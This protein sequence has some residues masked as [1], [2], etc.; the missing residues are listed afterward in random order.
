MALVP[1]SVLALLLVTSIG[2][3]Q[4]GGL[5]AEVIEWLNRNIA[6]SVRGAEFAILAL[7]SFTNLFVSVNTVA[8]IAAGPLAN[9]LRKR[10]RIHPYRTAN[11]LDTVS[12]SFPFLLPYAAAVVAAIAI[13]G[14]V[15]QRYDFVEVL[16]TSEFVPFAF[17]CIVLYPLMIIAV[18]TGFGRKRG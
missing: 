16:T 14:E 4:A 12:C 10:F 9:I 7:I 15:A 3:M 18:A 11:L 13:Q 6:R 5:L 8:M 2:I 1:T 17:Y